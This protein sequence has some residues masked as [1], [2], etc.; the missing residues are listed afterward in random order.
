M[1]SRKE[2]LL[3]KVQDFIHE[4]PSILGNLFKL[5][6]DN[7]DR[8]VEA[9]RNERESAHLCAL[10]EMLDNLSSVHLYGKRSPRL[11]TNLECCT[12]LEAIDATNRKGIG[13]SPMRK[14]LLAHA[15]KSMRALGWQPDDDFIVN[16][17]KKQQLLENLYR[18]F[19]CVPLECAKGDVV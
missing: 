4:D 7:W 5:V 10:E 6:S 18:N 11:F 8:M 15:A 16:I 1:L 14:K 19:P 2:E 3:K 9:Q 12:L 13:G 17:R